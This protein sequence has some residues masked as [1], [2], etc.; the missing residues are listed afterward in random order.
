MIVKSEI[1]D[2]ATSK[3]ALHKL[4]TKYAWIYDPIYPDFLPRIKQQNDI[5]LN[6]LKNNETKQILELGSG[7][8]R[9]SWLLRREGYESFALDISPQMVELAKKK[10][11]P[12]NAQI[13]DARNF[14][15]EGPL[16][17]VV[18]GPLVTCF[19]LGNE[20]LSRTLRCAHQSLSKGG[21]LLCEFIAAD[22]I[23]ANSFYNGFSKQEFKIAQGKITRF[24]ECKLE[25]STDAK[26][27][28]FSTYIFD[29]KD[30]LSTDTDQVLLRAFWPSEI[31]L[32][33][34]TEGFNI[35]ERFGFDEKEFVPLDEAK[36]K[37]TL[38]Y[39]AEKK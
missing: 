19:F 28:W 11:G 23:L 10:N 34:R 22:W 8:G 16:G 31:E 39:L 35:L 27:D 3:N 13:G 29:L 7:S 26:Y 2:D 38:L 15:T 5:L 20:D 36:A 32:F 18:L 9:Q 17:A 33:F 4:E 14:Q 12:D 21:L 30:G 25:L 24:N 6:R 1:I 37:T